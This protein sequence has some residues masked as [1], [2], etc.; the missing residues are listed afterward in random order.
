VAERASDLKEVTALPAMKLVIIGG[1]AGGASA[2]ARARRLSEDAE[3]VLVE[4]GPHVSFANCGLPY[5]LGG[6]IAREEDLL[7]QTPAGF[8]AR[9]NLDVR[10]E[11]EAIK[12]DRK[13][14]MVELR[15][16]RTSEITRE[17]Y[18][19]LILATGA[20]PLKPPIPGIE[21]PG[22]FTLRNIEDM[23]AIDRWI[24]SHAAKTA[25]VAGGGYIGLEMAEQLR[26]RGL[27]VTLAQSRP[28]VMVALDPEMAA[29]LH[30]ELRANGV[31]LRLADGV[32]AF[33]E[34][35]ASEEAA[36][37]VVVLKSG[38][39]LPADVVI[40]GLGVRPEADLARD[41]GLEIGDFGGVRVN[42]TMQTSDLHIW[43]IGDVVEVWNT[44]TEDW[45]LIPLA[46]PA[47]RMGRLAADVIFGRDRAY[48]GTWGTAI[49]RLFD[50]TAAC[51]GASETLLRQAGIAYT[52]IYLHPGSHA[53]YFPGAE[54]IALKLLFDPEDGDILGAQAVGR[55]GVDKRIDVIA[56]AMYA[57]LSVDDLTEIE[58]AYAPPFGSAKDPVNLA[59]M[60]AQDVVAGDSRVAQWSE[61]AGIDLATTTLLDVRTS[62]E[63]AHGTIPGAVHISLHELRARTG[64]LP[65]GRPVIVY[66][67]SGQR[68]YFAERILRQRGFDVRNLSGAWLTWSAA[69]GQD[70]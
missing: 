14:R 8:R 44:V 12:I 36:A 38:A 56:T 69:T 21:R 67:R 10:T 9:Y 20:K 60:I 39:R 52:A 32:A 4:R 45:C 53:G 34:P 6:E 40:L 24:A 11:T 19:A 62:A 66:C 41:A 3:I 63:V 65:V 51:T 37:S 25:V 29:Y 23:L 50:L 54:Q 15:D 16:V 26:R 49:L 1:V 2:A 17:R 59:G 43:A 48:Q 68:S 22:H 64:E 55:D 13:A 61:I 57:R 5:F 27:E 46:G 18:D 28:Q 35:A 42:S 31:D 47:N 70:E 33:E 30:A 7:V 58:L